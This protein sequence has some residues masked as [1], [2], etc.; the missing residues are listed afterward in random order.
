MSNIIQI[1]SI[2]GTPP[3][4]IYVCDQTI[5]YC[6]LV[7]G[8]T[9]ITPPLTFIV[10]PPLDTSTPIILKIIDSL[11]CEKIFLLTCGEIYGKLFEGFEVFLFQ[12]ASIYLYEGP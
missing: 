5:T 8:S 6:Y 4:D 12:D 2:S 1:T 9:F 11:G 10:P 3:Y 7:S